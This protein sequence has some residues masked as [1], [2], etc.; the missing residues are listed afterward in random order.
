MYVHIYILYAV[1]QNLF[2]NSIVCGVVPLFEE[3]D[4]KLV[5]TYYIYNI[6][7]YICTV[8]ACTD[9]IPYQLNSTALLLSLC[10]HT[11]M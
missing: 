1:G 3:N 7:M 8:C 10:M 2:P 11:C 5:C 4:W 6:Y 9:M